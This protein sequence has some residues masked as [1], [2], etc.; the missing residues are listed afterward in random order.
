MT[1]MA[2]VEEALLHGRWVHANEEDTESEM[3]LRP[4]GHALPPARGRT[5]FEFHPDGTYTERYPGP[6]D[7]PEQ[8]TGSWSLDGDRLILEAEGPEPTRTWEI[9]TADPDRLTFRT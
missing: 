3:V 1:H 2:G 4:G 8:S 9:K 6:V 7:V 5:S